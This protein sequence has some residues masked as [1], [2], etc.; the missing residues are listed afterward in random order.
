MSRASIMHKKNHFGIGSMIALM[1]GICLIL[2]SLSCSSGG[3]N[4]LGI[5]FAAGT[6]APPASLGLSAI[7]SF[8]A[9]VTGDSQSQGVNWTVAC[10][11]APIPQGTCGTITEHTASGYPTTYSAPF[12]FD[13]RTVPVGGT[14]TITATS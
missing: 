9:V 14:V 6:L 2:G 8:V 7:A 10:T 11:P 12:N 5:A 3:S 1:A 13:E 4:T